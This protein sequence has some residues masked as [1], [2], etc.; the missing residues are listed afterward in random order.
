MT[1]FSVTL[2]FFFFLTS[3]TA[4]VQQKVN[5][6]QNVLSVFN[7]KIPYNFGSILT[8]NRIKTLFICTLKLISIKCYIQATLL[9]YINTKESYILIN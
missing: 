1:R 9:D 6:L 5:L 7:G 4:K 3:I 8:K 2:G